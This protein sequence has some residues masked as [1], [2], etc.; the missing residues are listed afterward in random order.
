MYQLNVPVKNGMR[1]ETVY[2]IN[3]LPYKKFLKCKT[4]KNKKT[5]YLELACA[6][7]IETTTIE[8]PY[9][10]DKNGKKEYNYTPYGFMYHWQFCIE[11]MVFFGRTWTE[12]VIF[13]ERVKS[14]LELNS[15][16]RL[17][18]Y[19]HNL[20]FEFQFMKEFIELEEG[21][22]FA[23]D[24]RKP[25]K[26]SCNNAFEFRCSY[27]LSNMSLIKF[28]ENSQNCIHYKLEDK[29]NY[30]KIRTPK[31]PLSEIEQG[32]CYNDVRGLC[33]CIRDKMENDTLATIPLT[34]TGYVRRKYRSVMRTQKNREIF[35]KTRLYESEY[36]MLRNAFRG[37][38]THANFNYS[39]CILKNVHS[40]DLQSSYPAT[41]MMD[42][43]PTGKFNHATMDDNDKLNYYCQKY[44]CV[45]EIEIFNLKLKQGQV[46]PYID[47]AHCT[48][49]G[50]YINDNGRV[51]ESN[52]VKMTI[53]NVDL[54]IIREVYDYEGFTVNEFIYAEKGKLPNELRLKMLDFY[55]SKTLLK[56]VEG[57]EYEYAKSKNMLNST[58]G[59]CVTA[60]VHEQ[61]E[62]NKKTMTWSVETGDTEEE[63]TKFY[64]NRNNFLSYQWGVFVT[65]NARRRLQDM[66]NVVGEDVV[67]I[68]T[69]S[70]KFINDK[71]LQEFE[72]KNKIL[73]EQCETNDIPAYVDRTETDGSIKRFYL[74]IWDYEGMY[75]RF[76]TL[77]AKKYCFHKFNKKKNKMEFGVTV[78]GLGKKQGAKELRCINNF[79]I[80]KTIENSGRTTS[81]YNDEKRHKITVDGCTFE[82][83]S[84]IAI[85]D[86][87][88]T[89]GVTNE[90]WELIQDNPLTMV[91]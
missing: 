2:N 20:A 50:K 88:Y 77:G 69:D 42:Y 81:W 44:C 4:S 41:I 30:R 61:I 84:N 6:F 11:D 29:F 66:L 67:Y 74:G 56:G 79:V 22:L 39:N 49:I 33:E 46:I 78:S 34:N 70:I 83:A 23:K 85:L 7:D 24:K 45:F 68:D 54:S 48:K 90:Y 53:T 63:L 82:T 71:H 55:M 38:N 65:A 5:E 89:L 87:S 73:I 36:N 60:L 21:K 64:T 58:F 62:Y 72:N 26:F 3:D 80:G 91:C 19:V 8:P 13:L 10:L 17:V 18:I 28:C 75:S 59:M 27:F 25:M 9:T 52:Y 12:F 40:Y 35:E 86:T 57:K 16:R 14:V 76:K 37:G 15:N 51:L 31:T 32:Y 43:Y 1:T 47:L